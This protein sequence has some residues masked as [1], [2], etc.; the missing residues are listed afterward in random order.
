MTGVALNNK[1]RILVCEDEPALRNDICAELVEAGYEA[2]GVRD[3]NDALAF[4]AEGRPDL[5]LCDIAMPVLDGRGLLDRIRDDRPD[6]STVPFLFLTA[7]SDRQDIIAGKLGGADDYLVKPVDYEMLL[8]TVSAHLRL[9]SR[10]EIAVNDR[11][12]QTREALGSAENGHYSALECLAQ[13]LVIV[14]REAHVLYANPKAR[15]LACIGAGLQLD[16]ALS[17]SKNNAL[18]IDALAEVMADETGMVR[19]VIVTAP[20]RDRE[21]I[22]LIGRIAAVEGVQRAALVVIADPGTRSIPEPDLLQAA[23]NLTPKEA[24]LAALLAK[25][26]RSEEI[27]DVMGVSSTTVSYHLKNLF[28]KT[29][30]NRQSDLVVFILSLCALSPSR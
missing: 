14:D 4:L 5:I 29:Q 30:T 19:S 15:S 20:E 6:L 27:A 17:L 3:G 22:L 9:V 8:A 16:R 21:M 13:A 28:A 10:V 2:V 25:G 26:L 23:L 11:L 18:F 1:A 12:A 7:F 24:E